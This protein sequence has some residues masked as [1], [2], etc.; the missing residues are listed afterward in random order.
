MVQA[1][2]RCPYK[3][4]HDE[5]TAKFGCRNQRRT[6]SRGQPADVGGGD[7]KLD[8]RSAWESA[9]A[10]SPVD[11]TSRPEPAPAAPRRELLMGTISARLARSTTRAGAWQ[12]RVRLRRRVGRAGG[13]LLRPR[14]HLPRVRGAGR[15]RH[16]GA[17]RAHRRRTVSE[18]PV[19][20][21]VSGDGGGSIHRRPLRTV[22]APTASAHFGYLRAIS[23]GSTGGTGPRRDAPRR[24]RLPGRRTHR[25]LPRAHA[26]PGRG[27]RHH[28]RG[29]GAG[30]P[31]E[32]GHA[33]GQLVRQSATVRRQRHHEPGLL[34]RRRVPRR[35]AGGDRQR[36]QQR[37]P[38]PRQGAG[39]QAPPD[40]R[41]RHRRQLHDARPGV[42][43]RRADA[44]P[45]TLQVAGRAP[46]PGR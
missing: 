13:N 28:H 6:A 10:D 9:D 36:H 18:G 5:C 46:V 25:P 19:P 45:E 42:R 43:L 35:V 41:D 12:D 16:G 27:R 31:G 17:V 40:L 24:R 15:G 23:R 34:R 11:P 4:R 29:D 3:N 20:P 7:D 30:R 14:R 1:T 2:F 32:R 33:A 21:G 8:Y 38:R 39:H 22:A 37:H 44:G 26:R